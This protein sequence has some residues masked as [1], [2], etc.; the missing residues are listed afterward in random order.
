MLRVVPR[1]QAVPLIV[2]VAVSV[3][4]GIFTADEI[5]FVAV[6]TAIFIFIT[7]HG[8]VTHRAGRI[9]LPKSA[10]LWLPL[11]ITA[12]GLLTLPLLGY[13]SLGIINAVFAASMDLLNRRSPPTP[14]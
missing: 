11:L 10:W 12:T 5:Q 7:W 2:L 3:A 9:R 4:L 13:A 8:R 1:Q 6:M 14:P